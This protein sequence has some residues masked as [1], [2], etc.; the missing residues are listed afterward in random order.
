MPKVFISYK[1]QKKQLVNSIANYFTNSFIDVWLDSEELHTGDELTPQIREAIRRHKYFM[2]FL[3]VDY[4]DS[5]YCKEELR[6]VKSLY[7][8]ANNSKKICLVLLNS[9]AELEEIGNI[10]VNDLLNKVRFFS[11]AD[12]ISEN[13]IVDDKK[14]ANALLKE[15]WGNEDLEIL[16]IRNWKYDDL[17]LQEIPFKITKTQ[18]GGPQLPINFLESWDFNLVNFACFDLSD[19]KPIKYDSS[20]LISGKGPIW[21]Y[22]YLAIPFANKRNVF[23]MSKFEE[24]ECFICVYSKG[25]KMAGKVLYLDEMV[26]I[27]EDK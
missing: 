15:I 25:G 5:A 16:P 8:D 13:G 22:V 1:S 20:I 4:L 3:S 19:N 7:D 21:L 12:F 24:R 17:W 26:R 2:A 10:H 6:L 9:K 14:L 18:N 23:V 11:L 27:E